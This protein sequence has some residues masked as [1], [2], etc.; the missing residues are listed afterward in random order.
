MRKLNL[1]YSLAFLT[2]AFA[3]GC[4]KSNT[5]NNSQV[6]ATPYSL[7][8][9]DTAGALYNSTD[10]KT[11]N[12]VFSPDGVPT[13]S[14]FNMNGNILMVKNGVYVS[15]N[16]GVN[17]NVSY[18]AINTATF[19]S[20]NVRGRSFDL[21]QSM[22]IYAPEDAWR[23]HAY[24]C[25][26]EPSG[27][28]YFGIY[29]NETDGTY[30]SW[31]PEDYYDSVQVNAGHVNFIRITSFT[32]LEN[33]TIVAYDGNHQMG[34]YRENINM[35]WKE[36]YD[37]TGSSP[38]SGIPASPAVFSAGH[39][40]NRLILIDNYGA[41]GAVYSD[42]LGL[43]WHA[44][45]GLPTNVPLISVAAPFEQTCLVG[46]DSAGLY[47][48]NINTDAFEKVAGGLP[49]NLVVRSIAFKENIY[50]NDAKRQYIFLATNRGIYKSEDMGINWVLSVPGNFVSVY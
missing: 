48:L 5:I 10:G 9:T 18:D 47:K 49:E 44:Y 8:F 34:L 17:F 20:V 2:A 42:D 11:W 15:K 7:Y 37:N 41:S 36:M 22:S 28:N 12:V 24:I 45:A 4:K 35:R 32:K 14:L 30:G 46:T 31:K 21:N 29:W 1:L 25:S 39:I 27:S 40:H 26:R 38:M 43:N 6:I 19:P 23:N 16:N 3:V 50:K 13:R 33:G